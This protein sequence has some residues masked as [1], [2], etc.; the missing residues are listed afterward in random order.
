MDLG[1]LQTLIP[2]SGPWFW[3]EK[4]MPM[5]CHSLCMIF[6][7]YILPV[8][9]LSFLI[10]VNIGYEV[11]MESLYANTFWFCDATSCHKSYVK[12]NTPCILRLSWTLQ[13]IGY[14]KKWMYH[15]FQWLLVSMMLSYC[16]GTNHSN[17]NRGQVWW[18]F[19]WN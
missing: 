10:G 8:Q 12:L 16:F 3:K 1:A 19:L 18:G 17:G 9:R 15:D 5:Y 14:N 7:F 4:Y 2:L 13:W 6:L 11:N